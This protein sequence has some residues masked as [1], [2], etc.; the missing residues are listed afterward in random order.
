M[1]NAADY[2]DIWFKNQN[3]VMNAFYVCQAGESEY[4]C[5]TA[6]EAKSWRI[7]KDME[8]G[9]EEGKQTNFGV[10]VELVL[11]RETFGL[12]KLEPGA[13]TY[14]ISGKSN[15]EYQALHMRAPISRDDMFDLKCMAVK[16]MHPNAKSPSMESM[17]SMEAKVLKQ[18]AHE[19]H[20]SVYP[21]AWPQIPELEWDIIYHFR[22]QVEMATTR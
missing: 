16:L 2:S 20:W 9:I 11:H 5:R 21:A 12:P 10:L 22:D 13:P 7:K 6:I 18:A 8:A 1:R 14:M 19:G 4:P 3:A 15:T 17:V